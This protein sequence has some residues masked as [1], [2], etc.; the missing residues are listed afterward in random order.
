MY[1][2]SSA[3]PSFVRAFLSFQ[4]WQLV[5]LAAAAAAVQPLPQNTGMSLVAKVSGAT[6]ADDAFWADKC[7]TIP[8]NALFLVIDVGTSVRDFFKPTAGATMCDML[9]S[10]TKHQWSKDGIVWKTP[11]GTDM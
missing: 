2:S 8:E 6:Q 7:K 11:G 3:Q 5:W 10:G 4:A 1:F 9:Q